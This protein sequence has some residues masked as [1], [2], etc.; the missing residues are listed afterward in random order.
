MKMI[1]G[2]NIYKLKRY[3][4]LSFL[5]FVLYNY[6]FSI[7]KKSVYT[8]IVQNTKYSQYDIEKMYFVNDDYC[9]YGISEQPVED[10]DAFQIVYTLM[11]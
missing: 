9:N 6:A 10:G 2:N 3:I 8:S 4:S 1:Y 5:I 7:D 11:E